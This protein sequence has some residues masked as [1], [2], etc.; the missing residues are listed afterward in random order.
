MT[1]SS[2][3]PTL[4]HSDRGAVI[5]QVAVALLA[6]LAM[7]AFVLDY[8]VMWV[9]RGQAQNAADAG[10][11]SGAISLAFDNATDQAGAR[12]KAIA[13][14]QRNWV[15]GQQPDV[16]NA[17]VTFPPC[18]PGAP[19]VPDTCVKVD[20]FRNQ[21]PLG[22]PL[23]VFFARLV[24]V[25]DQGVR[26]TATAQI[27]TGNSTDCLRPW[28]VI[29]RWL[30]FGPE[31][32]GLLPSSTYDYYSTGQGND[33][34]QENDIYTPPTA[35]SPG[36]GYRLPED[37][38]RRF[39]IK[40]SS[41]QNVVSSGWFMEIRLPRL[42]GYN[43]GQVYERNITSCGGLPSALA[44]PG[45]V[46]PADIV[47]E[48]E[49]A[50]WAARGCYRVLTGN[51][52][53]PTEH[54]VDELID[55]DLGASWVDGTGIVGSTFSPPTRSPRVVPIG[56]IDI[57]DYLSRYPNGSQGIARMANIY[58]FFIEGMGDVRPDGTI[59]FPRPN[60]RDVIGRIMTIPSMARGTSTL[61]NSASFLRSI[62]LVR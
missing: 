24:D 3:R 11:L 17:D 49:A 8:G 1:I 6:L 25:P 36:T 42:D 19:G 39:A 27:V 9:S 52:V 60:G 29:D 59:D 58:G 38:G 32:P 44:E 5:I 40:T 62:I 56:V 50:Y 33:P 2:R 10:A 14:A 61:P 54:G 37:E 22:S 35:T 41:G 48:T 53:G 20:V 51:R 43:G 12:A 16:T 47:G 23:P 26:A 4:R 13:V 46:C 30:E 31:G 34:P 28:A 18:P 45:T 15:F 55:Q 57:A 21:R 7:S